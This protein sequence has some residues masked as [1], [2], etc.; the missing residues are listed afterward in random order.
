MSPRLCIATRTAFALPRALRAGMARGY[1]TNLLLL[2]L[3]CGWLALVGCTG[4]GNLFS[5]NRL[6][7]DDHPFLYR[8][9]RTPFI[10][11]VEVGGS[12]N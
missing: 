2:P 8:S 12:T 11:G 1:A 4:T 10:H 9:A 6:L 7:R 3:I 5:P